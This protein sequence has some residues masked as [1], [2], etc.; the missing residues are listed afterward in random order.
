MKPKQKVNKKATLPIL[1]HSGMDYPL[2][3]N[4]LA[5]VN[6]LGGVL[7]DIALFFKWSPRFALCLGTTRFLSYS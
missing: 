1:C 5:D 3:R 6:I 7:K 4:T 2:R